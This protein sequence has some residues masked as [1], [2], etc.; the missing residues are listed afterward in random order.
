ML[1]QH[2]QRMALH[3]EIHARPPEAVEAPVSLSH[4][5]MVCDADQR[6][7]SWAHLAELARDH[8]LPPPDAASTHVR[9]DLG[10][11][12]VRWEMHTECVTWTFM[13][14]ISADHF[15]EQEP[16]AALLAVSVMLSLIAVGVPDV[17]HVPARSMKDA[18]AEPVSE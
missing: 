4:V 6:A 15:G 13:R 14:R 12:R 1:T 16:E 8:H 9:L 7:A 17:F 10:P 5:V 18:D 3:N 2:P 11:Y